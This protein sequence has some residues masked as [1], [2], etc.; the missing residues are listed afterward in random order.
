MSDVLQA[1]LVDG[2]EDSPVD[3]SSS[4]ASTLEI[5]AGRSLL[6]DGGLLLCWVAATDWLLYQV[7]SYFAWAGLFLVVILFLGL[8]K[9]SWGHKM[10]ALLIA[11]VLVLVAFKLVW[12]GSWLQIACG[13]LLAVCFAMSLSGTAP[14]LP[15]LLGFIGLMI[16]GSLR[17]VCGYRLGRLSPQSGR[18][19]PLVNTAVLLPVVVVLVFGTLFVLANPDLL[20]SLSNRMNDVLLKVQSLIDGIG[21][22]ETI[23][24]LFSGLTMLGLL[25][26]LRAKLL[27]EKS[28]EAQPQSPAKMALFAAYFNT[29]LCV[30]LLFGVY[31]IFEF[32]TLWFRELPDD[33]YYA[34]YAHQGAFWLTVVLAL[35][36]MTLSTIFQRRTLLDPRIG[37]LKRLAW[38]WSVENL[39]LTIAILYRLYIYVDFNGMTR[40]RV[41]GVLG[42]SSVAVGFLLVV[43]KFHRQRSFVWLLHRQLWVP[44][45][46]VV[47]YAVLPVD[48]LVQRANV[49]QVLQGNLASSVQIVAHRTSAEGMLPL[50]RLIDCENPAIREG[51]RAMMA[52]WA[53]E[54]ALERSQGTESPRSAATYN[55]WTSEAGHASPWLEHDAV[56]RVAKGEDAPA[57]QHF[58]AAEYL[59]SKGL[60]DNAAK[61]EP[62]ASEPGSGDRAINAFFKYAYQWY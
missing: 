46:A 48:W 16:A 1:D 33:F 60:E 54:L 47:I 62:Y 4:T 15:E 10:S 11:G 53:S 27:S 14:F 29:L 61:W 9:R 17:R 31:L 12:C 34:G 25:Y 37:K 21:V 3:A 20:K 49:R 24:W 41:I 42:I 28:N 26:P 32:S 6:R 45:M 43:Y 22:D 57:W 55:Y 8:A 35:S 51:V 13:L 19:V 59:L 7:G 2:Q 30:I 56:E 36:T 44:V 50:L 5:V 40:M 18:V 52:I 23:F 39:V 38:V 58:Q